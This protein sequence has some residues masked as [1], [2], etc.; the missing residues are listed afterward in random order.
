MLL[1][2]FHRSSKTASL[3][4]S[5]AATLP[6]VGSG[7]GFAPSTTGSLLIASTG[8]TSTSLGGA[9]TEEPHPMDRWMKG[10]PTAAQALWKR[11]FRS[12]S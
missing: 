5:R 11:L 1:A 3:G 12:I 9:A 6:A 2:I 7:G 8:L 4:A 10:G